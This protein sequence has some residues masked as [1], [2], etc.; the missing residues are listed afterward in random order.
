MSFSWLD[1]DMDLG[2]DEVS[3][4]FMWLITGD[5]ILDHLAMVMFSMLLHYKVTFPHL[6]VVFSESKSPNTAPH[7]AGEELSFIL[8]GGRE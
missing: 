5:V 4:L 8:R 2:E 3:M 7:L 1:W 6:S